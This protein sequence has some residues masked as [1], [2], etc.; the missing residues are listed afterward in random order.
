MKISKIIGVGVLITVLLVNFVNSG[1]VEFSDRLFPVLASAINYDSENLNP[2]DKADINQDG[3]NDLDDIY[4]LINYLYKEGPAPN[5]IELGDFDENGK[6]N[7]LD[8]ASLIRYMIDNGFII[9]DDKG[10]IIEL[11]SPENEDTFKTSKTY[12]EIDFEFSVADLS[13]ID[14]CELIIDSDVEKTISNV[15]RDITIE[16]SKELDRDKYEGQMRC[17]DIYGNEGISEKWGF[18]IKKKSST[19][20]LIQNLI[21][22]EEDQKETYKFQSDL[23]ELNSNQEK[24]QN[25][26]SILDLNES[27]LLVLGLLIIITMILIVILYAKKY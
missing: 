21:I 20:D 16:I 1:A 22:N 9:L 7:L 6:T 27:L 19:N 5:P 10:P 12:K 23:I 8:I 13:E 17:Y 18:K 4:F 2:L 3:K 14:Y 15:E 24:D 26:Q 11:I 25:K